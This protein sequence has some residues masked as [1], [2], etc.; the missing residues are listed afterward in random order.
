MGMTEITVNTVYSMI[1]LVISRHLISRY[2]N[3]QNQ[4]KSLKGKVLIWYAYKWKIA[5]N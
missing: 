4:K 5:L 3:L 1:L 2:M